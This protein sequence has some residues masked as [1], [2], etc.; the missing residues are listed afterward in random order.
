MTTTDLKERVVE[1]RQLVM[2]DTKTALSLYEQLLVKIVECDDA[3]TKINF[4]RSSAALFT[5]LHRYNQA[6]QAITKAREISEQK[7]NF[8]WQIEVAITHAVLLTAE[9][10][11]E[12]AEHLFINTL[13]QLQGTNYD[14]YVAVVQTRLAILYSKIGQLE[15]ALQYYLAALPYYD[16]V[17][18]TLGRFSVR[19]NLLNVYQQMKM[20]REME[21]LYAYM[22]KHIHE[23]TSKS[24]L[25]YFHA[26][27]GVYLNDKG[28]YEEALVQA[29]LSI[30]HCNDPAN[31][32]RNA[33]AFRV[34]SDALHH[35]GKNKLSYLYKLRGLEAANQTNDYY[36]KSLAYLSTA[37]FLLKQGKIQRAKTLAEIGYSIAEQNKI[38]FVQSMGLDLLI[39][40]YKALGDT[41]QVLKLYEQLIAV[42]EELFNAEKVK[43]MAE[44]QTKY[45]VAQKEKLAQEL[46]TEVAEYNLKLLRSQMNPHFIFNSINSI[47]NFLLKSKTTEASAYLLHFAQL[48]RQILDATNQKEISL[49][50][51][52]EFNERYVAL[53]QLRFEQPFKYQVNVDPLLELNDIKIPPLL[54]QPFVENAIWHGLAHRPTPGELTIDVMEKDNVIT[55][56]I[57]DNGIGRNKSKEINTN[58]KKHQSLALN[59]TRN[60]IIEGLGGQLEI[61]DLV[62]GN[63][64]LGTKVIISWPL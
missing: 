64:P 38:L 22:N 31:Y 59:I 17:N 1:F 39:R 37:D 20:E 21:E 62:D 60:R 44:W 25:V 28:K 30:A 5:D 53:E 3:E 8:I 4:Y 43:S 52:L 54:L 18:D 47:N 24:V 23:C 7:Q 9:G 63:I 58:R 11:M 57:T 46:R 50:Q 36:S 10:E 42:K 13:H 45:E 34:K 15:K 26:N 48:M 27:Y 19:T 61:V 55:L 49:K 14:K 32:T 16:K 41:E 56:T 6:H 33:I 2:N 40:V 29:D 51:E 35:L 12:K